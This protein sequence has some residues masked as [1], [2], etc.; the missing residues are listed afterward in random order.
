MSKYGF[1]LLMSLGL[2]VIL[3]SVSYYT[4]P[5]T[6]SPSLG[7][8]FFSPLQH[9]PQLL[10]DS[11]PLPESF[12]SRVEEDRSFFDLWS[13]RNVGQVQSEELIEKEPGRE[14]SVIS[15]IMG[16]FLSLYTK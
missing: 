4:P 1:L 10:D 14:W 7:Q 6:E 9:A 13:L 3:C 5:Q 16:I 8:L 11:L 2:G 12:Q 15:T